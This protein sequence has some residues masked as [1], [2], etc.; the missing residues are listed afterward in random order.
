MRAL[1]STT[2]K[3]SICINYQWRTTKASR[4][5]DFYAPLRNLNT[6]LRRHEAPTGDAQD[7]LQ[8]RRGRPGATI[9]RLKLYEENVALGVNSLGE[10]ARIRILRDRP[11]A[12]RRAAPSQNEQSDDLLQ[13]LQEEKPTSESKRPFQH[14]DELHSALVKAAGK[15]GPSLGRCRQVARQLLNGFTT[16]QLRQYVR[17]QKPEELVQKSKKYERTEWICGTTEFPKVALERFEP[18]SETAQDSLLFDYEGMAEKEREKARTVETIMR[19]CWRLHP[20]EERQRVGEVDFKVSDICLSVLMK[21]QELAFQA[22]SAKFD[23]RIEVSQSS[24]LVRLTARY[25]TSNEAA[26]AIEEAISSVKVKDAKVGLTHNRSKDEEYLRSVERL[27]NTMIR[28]ETPKPGQPAVCR[29][30]H[31]TGNPQSF[32][33]AERLLHQTLYDTRDCPTVITTSPRIGTTE[34]LDDV[35]DASSLPM[36]DRRKAWSRLRVKPSSLPVHAHDRP[37]GDRLYNPERSVDAQKRIFNH[38][39][40]AWNDYEQPRAPRSSNS[41]WEPRLRKT[42]TATLGRMAVAQPHDPD[43][44]HIGERRIVGEPPDLMMMLAELVDPIVLPS[45]QQELHICLRPDREHAFP[46]MNIVIERD[47]ASPTSHIRDVH[48]LYDQRRNDV[49]LLK[50]AT[51]IRFESRALIAARS[52]PSSVQEFISTSDLDVWGDGRLAPEPLTISIPRFACREKAVPAMP[53]LPWEFI[54]VQY[55]LERLEYR[56]QMRTR[57]QGYPLTYATIEGGRTGGRRTELWLE[58]EA[59]RRRKDFDAEI[60]AKLFEQ[61]HGVVQELVARLSI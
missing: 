29:I 19:G 49:L 26:A 32:S 14:M 6:T 52:I 38:L 23:V 5:R 7:T 12:R 16:T 46:S 53:R 2:S 39:S 33:D 55:K 3:L 50:Q 15:D 18:G 17:R 22:T 43:S 37:E 8:R 51:D 4:S 40:S 28:L 24:S 13:A 27:T 21:N 60:D 42:F 59:L 36:H 54:K 57:Y 45:I 35:V 30:Y 31:F 56:S 20:A 48:L 44:P 10:P 61:W 25:A 47:H 41:S 34:L 11:K 1:S 9:R 58:A